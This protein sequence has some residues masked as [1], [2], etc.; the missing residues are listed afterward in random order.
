M[1]C[2]SLHC[3]SVYKLALA[4]LLYDSIK[5]LNW[6]VVVVVVPSQQFNWFSES[7]GELTKHFLFT[8]LLETFQLRGLEL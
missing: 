4:R 7:T 3:K 6:F 5:E 1:K 8:V 2:M